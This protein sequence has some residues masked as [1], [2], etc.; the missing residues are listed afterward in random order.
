MLPNNFKD[1]FLWTR[2]AIGASRTWAPHLASMWTECDERLQLIARCE[3]HESA[4]EINLEI[5]RLWLA[6]DKKS[7]DEDVRNANLSQLVGENWEVLGKPLPAVRRPKFLGVQQR[8]ELVITHRACRL[9]F[10]RRV[11]M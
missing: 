3:I 2:P 11:K 9:A 4:F 8:D 6:L 5:A 7:A 10:R 1:A